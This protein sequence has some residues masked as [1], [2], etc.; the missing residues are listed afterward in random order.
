MTSSGEFRLIERL[1]SLIPRRVQG[2]FPIGDDAAILP[3]SSGK[4]LL[5]STDVIVEGVDFL[6]GKKGAR[7]EAIGHKALAVNLSD[8][9]AMGARPLAFIAA[10]GIPKNFS[11]KSVERVA[12]GMVDL[13]KKFKTKWVGGDI[14]RSQKFFVSVAILGEQKPKKI[15]KRNGAKAGDFIYV[16]G[17]LGGSILGR[18]LN[19]MPR[20]PEGLYLAEKFRPSAMIDLS[21]GLI[22]DLGHILTSSKKGARLELAKIPISQ[23]ARKKSKDNAQK[24]LEYALTD[25]EDFELLFTLS[26]NA[27]KHLEKEWKSR[28]PDVRLTPIGV[29]DSHV[30]KIEW[31]K[32]GKR[33]KLWF[34]KK[35]FS[36]F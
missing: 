30:G 31:Q 33:T 8:I 26:R 19:F 6:L 9:A 20:V 21:D 2:P 4:S 32:K 13:A 3:L 35:G 7:P 11:E 10:I 34:H 14:T 29:I 25:G 15:V 28:F 36:H 23:A 18:Q 12:K 1:K 22:Q 5:F 27:A 24:A 16:T 17:D